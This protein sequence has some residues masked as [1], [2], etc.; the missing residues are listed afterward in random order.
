MRCILKDHVKVESGTVIPPDM[1]IPPFS[2]VSGSPAKISGEV[3]ESA[4]TL[5]QVDAVARF[6]AFIPIPNK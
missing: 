6:K 5:A 3:L 1:V 4:T 2:I